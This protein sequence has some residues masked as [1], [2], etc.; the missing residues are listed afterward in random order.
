MTN[1]IE[2]EGQEIPSGKNSFQAR[3]GHHAIETFKV[4]IK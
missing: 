2:E 1:I 3:V 4:F